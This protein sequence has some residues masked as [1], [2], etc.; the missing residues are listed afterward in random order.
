MIQDDAL[1]GA[2]KGSD[3]QE[4]LVECFA[5]DESSSKAVPGAQVGDPLRNVL[6]CREPKDQIAE[7]LGRGVGPF[8]RFAVENLTEPVRMA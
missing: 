6:L 4:R 2:G 7:Q 8:A 1:A 3:G 5:G